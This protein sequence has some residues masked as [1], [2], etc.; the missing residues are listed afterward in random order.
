MRVEGVVEGR[1]CTVE[2][3]GSAVKVVLP[4][5]SLVLLVPSMYVVAGGAEVRVGTGRLPIAEAARILLDPVLA[6]NVP[7]ARRATMEASARALAR[8]ARGEVEAV[9]RGHSVS[10]GMIR[11][12]G[13]L[14]AL[15]DGLFLDGRAVEVDGGVAVGWPWGVVVFYN[16]TRGPSAALLD[17][18]GGWR[19]LARR[20]KEWRRRADR[21][22]G[23]DELARL[24]AKD[25]YS[26]KVL[27]E[28]VA[29]LAEASPRLAEEAWRAMRGASHIAA[30]TFI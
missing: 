16:S 5:G 11:S 9:R 22:L 1:P 7:L 10:R 13:E 28:A 21:Y 30:A 8:L 3:G 19:D 27:E 24:A 18:R 4:H 15:Y 6:A 2:L 20:V 17:Y 29:R 12:S 25:A 14:D 23:L 26:W